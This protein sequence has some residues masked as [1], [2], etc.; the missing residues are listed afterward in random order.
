MHYGTRSLKPWYYEC[1]DRSA[2]IEQKAKVGFHVCHISKIPFQET[3]PHSLLDCWHSLMRPSHRTRHWLGWILLVCL[4]L[5]LDLAVASGALLVPAVVGNHDHHSHQAHW[6]LAPGLAVHTPTS[7]EVGPLCKASRTCCRVASCC[8]SSEKT[9][10]VSKADSLWRSSVSFQLSHCQPHWPHWPHLYPASH[11]CSQVSYF[12]CPQSQSWRA[13]PSSKSSVRRASPRVCFS[14]ESWCS[15][16][17]RGWRCHIGGWCTNTGRWRL[18]IQLHASMYTLI[19]GWCNSITWGCRRY[20][21]LWCNNHHLRLLE[22]HWAQV[23]QHHL[24]L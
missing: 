15:S 20:I 21:G 2:C 16:C 5:C 12:C 17:A 11:P 6:G 13:V 10:A 23:Q 19:S 9:E 7:D 14:P 18:G 1:R 24:G 3:P 22:V 4:D 8:P